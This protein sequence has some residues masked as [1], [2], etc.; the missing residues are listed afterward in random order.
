[1]KFS[2]TVQEK[3]ELLIQASTCT[4]LTVEILLKVVLNTITLTYIQQQIHTAKKCIPIW[5]FSQFH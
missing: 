5:I 4:R 2:M 3:G 1:M